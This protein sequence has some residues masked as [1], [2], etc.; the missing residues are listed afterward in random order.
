MSHRTFSK[1]RAAGVL[2]AMLGAAG[3]PAESIQDAMRAA[4]GQGGDLVIQ[5]AFL[6]WNTNLAVP[7]PGNTFL[8]RFDVESGVPKRVSASFGPIYTAR[9]RTQGKGRF[10]II[11]SVT[12]IDFDSIDGFDLDNGELS[13]PVA[14]LLGPGLATATA[15]IETTLVQLT[16]AYGVTENLDVT[17]S[18]PFLHTRFDQTT[19][20]AV[21]GTRTVLREKASTFGIG[22]MH[23]SAKWNFYEGANFALGAFAA[24]YFP[25]GDEQ[26]FRGLESWRLQPLLFVS[27]KR[28]R[29]NAHLNIGFDFGETDNADNEFRYK[30]AAEYLV[31][32]RLSVSGEIMGRYFFNNERLDLSSLRGTPRAAS[33][34]SSSA[35]AGLKFNVSGDA[36][37]FANAIFAVDDAGLRSDVAGQ[38]G[39]D[40][41]F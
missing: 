33:D 29:F 35:V 9:A 21:A 31:T 36:V 8:Y 24:L 1:L 15:D 28:E 25:T 10:S 34:N 14:T 12:H 30:L 20:I 7:A 13:F 5:G 3:A 39:V 37:V 6:A 32:P 27:T 4:N 17:L 11:S 18:L 23:A 22:D 16:G 40:I 26:E 19:T 41:G 2:V 38:I